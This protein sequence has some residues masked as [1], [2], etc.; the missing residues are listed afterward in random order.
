MP[1]KWKLAFSGAGKILSLP[2]SQKLPRTCELEKQSRMQGKL[3]TM[4]V[5]LTL[6]LTFIDQ[7]AD[8]EEAVAV[9]EE[10]TT[11]DAH[12]KATIMSLEVFDLE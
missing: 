6:L 3:R 10:T 12:M 5:K 11:Q 4:S 1:E 8:E 2:I 9:E 7:V